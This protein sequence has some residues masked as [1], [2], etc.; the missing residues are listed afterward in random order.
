MQ[1]TTSFRLYYKRSVNNLIFGMIMFVN[2]E[3]V[4]VKTGEKN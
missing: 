2:E 4:S 1:F 3:K